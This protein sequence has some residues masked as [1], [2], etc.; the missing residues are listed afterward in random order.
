MIL[1]A[2]MKG[3]PLSSQIWQHE[4]ADGFLDK[5]GAKIPVSQM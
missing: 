2:G 5:W 1:D 3:P 4:C